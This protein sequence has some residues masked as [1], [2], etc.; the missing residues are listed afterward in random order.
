MTIT[1]FLHDLKLVDRTWHLGENGCIRSKEDDL[2]PIHEVWLDTNDGYN[3]GMLDCYHDEGR[4][5]GLSDSAIEALAA[6]ADNRSSR[7]LR[8]RLLLAC[9]LFE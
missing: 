5:L 9:G 4:R 3:E 2:C 7:T 8:K 1:Q 6:S